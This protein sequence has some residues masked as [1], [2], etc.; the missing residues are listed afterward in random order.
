M[1]EKSGGTSLFTCKRNISDL[2]I[3]L[4]QWKRSVTGSRQG[5]IQ[6]NNFLLSFSRTNSEGLEKTREYLSHNMMVTRF[7]CNR[8]QKVMFQQ[9]FLFGSTT[10]NV[11]CGKRK[12]NK[13]TFCKHFLPATRKSFANCRLL[14]FK[15]FFLV[16]NIIPHSATRNADCRLRKS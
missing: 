3:T 8:K 12:L 9:V 15:I 11:D 6:G 5:K 4:Y 16:T 1:K 2:G 13:I 7:R 10:H 14:N